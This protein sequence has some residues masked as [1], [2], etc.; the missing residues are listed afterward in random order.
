MGK[1]TAI[2]N[3]AASFDQKFWLYRV[4]RL[5]DKKVKRCLKKVSGSW[6]ECNFCTMDFTKRE[7]HGESFPFPSQM[8]FNSKYAAGKHAPI[9]SDLDSSESL[10]L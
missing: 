7:Q 6:S 5:W 4:L 10:T 3:N 8:S 1:E 9:F 2:T